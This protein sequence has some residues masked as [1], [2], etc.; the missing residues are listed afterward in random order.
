MD[1]TIQAAT[2]THCG[3]KFQCQSELL[4]HDMDRKFMIALVREVP[5]V[6]HFV[7]P[8]TTEFAKQL[9]DYTLRFVTSYNQLIEKI[10]IF[11]ADL[12]D[13]VIE[14]L[15][16]VLWY[17]KFPKTLLTNDSMF[18]H[19]AQDEKGGK[20]NLWFIFFDTAQRRG[21]MAAPRSMYDSPLSAAEEAKMQQYGRGEWKLVNQSNVFFGQEQFIG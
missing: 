5:G 3:E 13:W 20:S 10:T 6:P 17:G 11:E 7:H 9:P 18:F 2:C 21:Q 12:I 16:L 4:Y 1:R 15:K 8:L 19:S 14:A